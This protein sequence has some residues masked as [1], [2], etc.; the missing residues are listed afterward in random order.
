VMQHE[1]KRTSSRNPTHGERWQ[2][3]YDANGNLTRYEA[4]GL[5]YNEDEDYMADIIQSW[6]YDANGNLT[7]AEEDSDADGKP[8]YIETWQYDLDGNLTRSDGDED[9]DGAIEDATTYQYEATGWG[10]LFSGVEAYGHS[11]SPPLKPRPAPG[12]CQH[13]DC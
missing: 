7:R 1:Y 2:Y 5:V 9:G 8:D 10:H 3:Q 11:S 6:Q 4:D 12:Q 13:E